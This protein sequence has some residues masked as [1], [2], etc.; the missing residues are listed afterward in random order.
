MPDLL[1]DPILHAVL[2]RATPMRAYDAFATADGL[3]GWFTDGAEVDARTGGSIRFRWKAWGPERYT[4]EDGGPVVEAKPGARLVFQWHP[5]GPAYATTVE[6]DFEHHHEGTVVRLREHGYH[7]TPSG[8]R[9]QLNCAAGWGEA[10]A[11]AKFWVEHGMR[12]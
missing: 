8:R 6:V 3:D 10:L 12:Y 1:P 5:D 9:A 2:V 11:L 4:G 7:D